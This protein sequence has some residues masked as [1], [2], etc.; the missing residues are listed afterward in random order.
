MDEK[1]R[2]AAYVEMIERFPELEGFIADM[3]ETGFDPQGA[4]YVPGRSTSTQPRFPGPGRVR[5]EG[6]QSKK[7]R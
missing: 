7:R 1:V 2:K 6:F 3:K 4:I 5:A